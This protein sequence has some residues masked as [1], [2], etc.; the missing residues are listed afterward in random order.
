MMRAGDEVLHSQRGNNNVYCQDNA[1][2][3]FDW[4]LVETHRDMLRFVRELI[5]LRKRHPS[6]RR[7]RFLTGRP[8]P[9]A[10]LPDVAWHGER[11]H[12]PPWHDPDARL[13]AF[14]LAGTRP[15]ESPLHVVLN[16]SDEA[17]AV[18]IPAPGRY[19]WHR[20]LDTSL[21]PPHDIVPRDGQEPLRDRSYLVQARSVAVL[22]A[23]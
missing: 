4:Q 1:L 14:T 2:A 3:W 19:V 12:E 9:G 16:M 18:A 5:A 20:A 13:L 10:S 8:A 11:L 21:S 7:Q 6:L 23:H 15:D 17:R 22:E